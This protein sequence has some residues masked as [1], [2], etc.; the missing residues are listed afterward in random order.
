MLDVEG[1]LLGDELLNRLVDRFLTFDESFMPCVDLALL[2]DELLN[3][4]VDRFLPFDE[5]GYEGGE[6]C[7][8]L[9]QFQQFLVQQQAADLV[10][11]L[12]IV[13][14]GSQESGLL[15]FIQRSHCRG[16]WSSP[17]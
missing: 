5:S 15:V 13:L 9:R 6:L 3:R 2:G 17:L 11:E 14:Q 1:F 16:L 8:A 4:L 7:E 10:A 12:E